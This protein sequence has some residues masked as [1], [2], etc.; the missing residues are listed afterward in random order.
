MNWKIT[1]VSHL[2]LSVAT[3]TAKSREDEKSTGFFIAFSL[4]I[5][6]FWKAGVFFQVSLFLMSVT[7]YKKA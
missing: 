2:I 7:I 4:K 5:E 1:Q 3:L 6:E